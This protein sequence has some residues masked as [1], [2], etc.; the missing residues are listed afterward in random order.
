MKAYCFWILLLF[1]I[2]YGRDRSDTLC[3]VLKDKFETVHSKYEE[4]TISSKFLVRSFSYSYY[5]SCI[6]LEFTPLNNSFKIELASYEF[7]KLYEV[8]DTVVNNML[9]SIYSY[10]N[11]AKTTDQ[12]DSGMCDVVDINIGSMDYCDTVCTPYS[13]LFEGHVLEF[14]GEIVTYLLVCGNEVPLDDATI[15]KYMGESK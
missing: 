2:A 14:F 3:E 4:H 1:L 10:I 11:S 8:S 9:S 13:D 6:V 7:I 5:S 15:E 12:A